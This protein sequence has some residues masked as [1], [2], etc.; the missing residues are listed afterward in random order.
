MKV[1][2]SALLLRLEQLTTLD[3]DERQ[4]LHELERDSRSVKKREAVMRRG[5]VHNNF[6]ILRSGWATRRVTGADGRSAITH[7]FCPGDLI[8]LCDLGTQSTPHDIIMQTDG[9]MSLF[10]TSDL[11]R[12]AQKHP[13]L[14][15]LLISMSQIEDVVLRDRFYAATRLSA[16]DRLMHFLLCIQSKVPNQ[17]EKCADRFQMPLSQKE[18]GDALGLTDIYVNRLLR[19]LTDRDEISVERPYM[20]IKAPARWTERVGFHDRYQETD[21]A[22]LT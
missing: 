1:T 13:R 8:G 6:A 11:S 4:A 5:T 7:V 15:L 17:G 2:S 20:R 14:L 16:E 21:I 18:I 10:D 19:S 22:W 9:S 3:A 12:L